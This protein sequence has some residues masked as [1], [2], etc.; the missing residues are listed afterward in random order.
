MIIRNGNKMAIR[1]IYIAQENYIGVKK[2]NI[3]FQWYPGFSVQ[4]KQRSIKSL[5]EEAFKLGIKNILEISSKSLNTLGIN[6]SSFNLFFYTKHNNLPISVESAFQGS[7][8][9]ENGGPY[10]DLLTKSS[11]EAKKDVRIRNSGKLNYF[12]LLNQKFESEP[13]TYFYDW[14]YIQTLSQEHNKNL[15]NEIMDYK[16]FTDIEFNPEKSINCQAYS[17]ALYISLKLNNK[18]DFALSSKENFLNIIKNMYDYNKKEV[19]VI[20]KKLF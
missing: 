15:S 4:Q 17:A 7:K 16:A 9:F 10:K 8:V 5:H 3:E 12:Q 11:M 18:L 1:P 13:K 19:K 20:Q 2:I 6:L 14:L